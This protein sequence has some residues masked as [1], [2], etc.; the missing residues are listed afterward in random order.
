MIKLDKK[1]YGLLKSIDLSEM[2]DHISFN[3]A[4]LSFETDNLRLLQIILN[5]EIVTK[6][7][8]NQNEVTEYGRA[9]YALYD[10]ILDQKE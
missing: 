10:A 3:D 6:G 2:G 1:S 7:M 4:E 9:L 5:E 8:K